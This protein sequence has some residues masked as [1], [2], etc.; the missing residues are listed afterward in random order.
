MSK[1]QAYR[2]ALDTLAYMIV[3]APDYPPSM[4]QTFEEA[5]AE[6][7]QYFEHLE[8]REQRAVSLDNVRMSR[9]AAMRAKRLYDSGD[10]DPGR[11]EIQYAHRYLDLAKSCKPAVEPLFE[12]MRLPEGL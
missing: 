11:I 5:F 3:W 10:I 4:P 2:L 7:C 1:R 12:P 6:L 9:E 8:A